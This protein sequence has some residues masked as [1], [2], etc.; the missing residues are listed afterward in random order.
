MLVH[1]KTPSNI[2]TEKSQLL[3]N[4]LQ[5]I[6]QNFLITAIQKLSDHLVKIGNATSTVLEQIH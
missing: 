3:I 6:K 4:K 1:S 5:A 2:N